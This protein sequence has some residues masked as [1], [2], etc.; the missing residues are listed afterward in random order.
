MTEQGTP[1]R[2][3]PTQEEIEKGKI[4]AFLGYLC[5]FLIPL[6]AARDNKFAMFHCEQAI[7]LI[8]VFLVSWIINVVFVVLAGATGMLPLLFVG[9]IG[10]LFYFVL[11][12]IGI[13]NSLT[14]KVTPLPIVGQF[15]AKL[16]LVK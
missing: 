16:N 11:W 9:Y 4:M 3:V 13:I 2:P 12:I 15:G 6:L 5:C 8:G 7:V 1:T 14:G 10:Y